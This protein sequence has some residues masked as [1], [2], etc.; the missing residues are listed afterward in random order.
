MWSE[1]R[2]FCINSL[3]T[4]RSTQDSGVMATFENANGEMED[5]CGIVMSI[6]KFDYRTFNIHALDVKWFSEPLHRSIHANI[7]RHPSGILA[8]DSTRVWERNKD[9]LVL[10][11]HCEQV[12]IFHIVLLDITLVIMIFYFFIIKFQGY[13]PSGY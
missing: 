10:P 12:L 5:F 9:S 2:H 3:D 8:I 6:L 1:G 11:Q 4:K 13:L 7:R